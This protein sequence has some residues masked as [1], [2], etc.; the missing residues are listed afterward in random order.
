[1]TILANPSADGGDRKYEL[2]SIVD[3][4]LN[5]EPDPPVDDKTVKTEAD[6]VYQEHCPFEKY[7]FLMQLLFLINA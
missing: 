3:N 1:M 6:I 5:E 2:I 7:K 4:N